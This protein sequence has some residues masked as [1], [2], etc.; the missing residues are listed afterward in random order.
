MGRIGLNFAGLSWVESGLYGK[1]GDFFHNMSLKN[2][3]KT[4]LKNTG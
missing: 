1:S 3:R 2:I 4:S